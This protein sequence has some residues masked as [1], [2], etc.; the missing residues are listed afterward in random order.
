MNRRPLQRQQWLA[1]CDGAEVRADDGRPSVIRATNGG[2]LD[3]RAAAEA[4]AE[5]YGPGLLIVPEPSFRLGGDPRIAVCLDVQRSLNAEAKVANLEG[6]VERQAKKIRDLSARLA[7]KSLEGNPRRVY[8]ATAKDDGIPRRGRGYRDELIRCFK[9]SKGP[10]PAILAG[11]ALAKWGDHA[12]T[13]VEHGPL[14]SVARTAL[15]D[16][17]QAAEL[18]PTRDAATIAAA[19]KACHE[20]GKGRLTHRHAGRLLVE[21]GPERAL[22][23]LIRG[24]GNVPSGLRDAVAETLEAA[25]AKPQQ[26]DISDFI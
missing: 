8:G 6:E 18:E 21:H 23:V 7:E 15:T 1:L 24:E 19:I 4:I 10:R 5:I 14:A 22:L 12:L 17:L 11:E 2:R 3:V 13:Y 26:T 16:A 9:Q 25:G 20:S